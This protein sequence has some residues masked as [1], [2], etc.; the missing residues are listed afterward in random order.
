MIAYSKLDISGRLFYWSVFVLFC[1][2]W[3][4]AVW[5]GGDS[6]ERAAPNSLFFAI[7]AKKHVYKFSSRGPVRTPVL[8]PSW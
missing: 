7:T 6:D 5:E 1:C 4:G 8:G 3:G 2:F